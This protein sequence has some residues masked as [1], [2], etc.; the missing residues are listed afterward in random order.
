MTLHR[1]TPAYCDGHSDGHYALEPWIR[2]MRGEALDPRYGCAGSEPA[3]LDVPEGST[4]RET[5]RGL[6]VTRSD[7]VVTYFTARP[8]PARRRGRA[9]AVDPPGAG[10]G[11]HSARRS[12]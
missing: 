2:P 10:R 9:G 7:G 5:A 8:P 12:R 3:V 4:V 6:A 1:L 11:R